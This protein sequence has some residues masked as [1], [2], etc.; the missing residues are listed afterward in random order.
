MSI[1]V[2]IS[3]GAIPVVA[4]RSASRYAARPWRAG[5]ADRGP[6][7]DRPVAEHVAGDLQC[8]GVDVVVGEVVVPGPDE[9]VQGAFDVGEERVAAQRG[10]QPDRAGL[11]GPGR[12]VEAD[13]EGVGE[14]FAGW[15]GLA[16]LGAGGV[17]GGPGLRAVLVR[18]EGEGER[19]VGFQVAVGV[20]VD[21]VDRVGVEFRASRG[22][23]YGRG[24]LRGP[25][26][27]AVSPEKINCAASPG[28][29]GV[30]APPNVA[31][32][33]PRAEAP[34]A[35]WSTLRVSGLPGHGGCISPV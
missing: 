35:G 6:H 30:R 9:S 28:P 3:M 14:L 11:D 32:R 2:E 1:S 27:A 17:P 4:K 10:G 25:E 5:T 7:A 19:D 8:D 22:R 31:W 34:Y 20:D 15:L 23:G 18:G 21:P 26:G 12:A 13:R 16:G 33:V 24:L 29:A